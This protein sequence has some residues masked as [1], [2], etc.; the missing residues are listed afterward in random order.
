MNKGLRRSE[1]AKSHET[2]ILEVGEIDLMNKGLRLEWFA[3]SSRIYFLD[4]LETL[5]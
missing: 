3:A 5:T 2:L 4:E 1:G